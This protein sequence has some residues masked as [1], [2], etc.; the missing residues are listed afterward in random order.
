MTFFFER[1]LTGLHELTTAQR[2][3]AMKYV[4]VAWVFGNFW[5]V[6]AL[7]GTVVLTQLCSKLGAGPAHFG[8][9]SSIPFIAALFSLPSSMWIDR[10]GNRKFIFLAFMLSQRFVWLAIALVPVL[11]F[12]VGGLETAA[13]RTGALWTVLA[14]L[15][16][17]GLVGAVGS[18]AWVSWMADLVPDRIRG[19]YFARRRQ[20]GI[21]SAI[22][23]AVASG[24]ILD[25][26]AARGEYMALLVIGCIL[27][28][29]AVAG[30]VDI[31]LFRYVP[32]VPPLSRERPPFTQSMRAALA[33]RP[34]MIFCLYLGLIHFTIAPGGQFT[35][36]Y[37]DESLKIDNV[38]KQ[39][40]TQVGPMLG[41]LAVLFMWGRLVDRV[42]RK[43]LL[44]IASFGLVPVGL[45]WTLMVFGHHWLGYVL[46]IA[47]AVLWAAI[48]V[49]NLNLVLDATTM[50]RP[51]ENG[52][53]RRVG[54]SA[55][56]AI[57]TAIFSM[58]GILG[59]WAAGQFVEAFK[60]REW[61]V[62]W[63][64]TP[65]PFNA[66]E[67]LFFLLATI[68][69]ATTV[70]LLPFIREK[71][72]HPTGRALRMIVAEMYAGV[73]RGISLPTRVIGK[74]RR[75]RAEA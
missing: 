4:T 61:H 22:T 48:E 32:H 18:P 23:A 20:L 52:Q 50:S 57:N 19:R 28:V 37:L 41:L 70:L 17:G 25:R 44:A 5:A 68:R 33:D 2:R 51:D 43:P 54:G 42:G 67:V 62:P 53:P 11:L 14:L 60:G 75:T 12:F 71:D 10:S 7:P 69:F 74:R 6:L 58:S 30:I 13:V 73:V 35:L 8:L 36:L 56:W 27:L 3:T 38:T 1:L 24:L 63:L 39:L 59:C 26:Y 15:A 9:I 40:M 55:F 34:F 72:A 49:A 64:N 45:G 46:S 66:Y 16:V 29:A 47:G 21:L 31:W 65:R